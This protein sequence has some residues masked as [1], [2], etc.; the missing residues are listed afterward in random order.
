MVTCGLAQDAGATG[1]ARCHEAGPERT[2]KTVQVRGSAW[3]PGD[4]ERPLCKPRIH[5]AF[6]YVVA[7]QEVAEQ[8]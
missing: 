6:R 5:G 7:E 4:R 8:K 1:C 3:L 2:D